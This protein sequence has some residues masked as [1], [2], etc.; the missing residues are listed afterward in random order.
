MMTMTPPPTRTCLRTQ[1]SIEVT[2]ELQ[3]DCQRVGA[4]SCLGAGHVIALVAAPFLVQNSVT[5]SRSSA[6]EASYG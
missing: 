3:S 6:A 1:T 4:M 2:F 5:C